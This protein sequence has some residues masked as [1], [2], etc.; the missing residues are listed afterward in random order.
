MRTLYINGKYT[1]QPMTGVQRCAHNLVLA[2]D[3]LG[4][5]AGVTSTV[6]LLPHAGVSP[7]L[8]SMT[9]RTVGQPGVSLHRWEQLLLPRAARDGLLLNLAGSGPWLGPV[10][11]DLLHDAA[12]FD[13]PEAYTPAFVWWYRHLFRRRARR[14][15]HLMTVSHHARGRLARALSVSPQRIAVVHNGGDHLDAVAADDALMRQHGLTGRAY[16]LAVASA[17]RSKNLPRLI[18][19]FAGLPAAGRPLLVLAGGQTGAGFMVQGQAALPPGVLQLPSPTDAALKA[20]YQGAT[21]LIVPSLYEGF[22]LPALE[23]MRLGCPVVAADAAALPE[24]CANAALY[25]DPT[26]VASIAQGLARV[27]GEPALRSSLSAAGRERALP[28]TWAAA[29]RS[30]Q[31]A[32]AEVSP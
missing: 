9:V 11:A 26:S 29:G 31:A 25:V 22:G 21:A 8:Q 32:L 18:E 4:P 17:N 3:A 14:G 19:A 30:L 23:A 15:D 6:L 7:Q 20:L 10:Q 28:F 1:A 16:L 2:L 12:V 5:T 24:V 13:R 27:I